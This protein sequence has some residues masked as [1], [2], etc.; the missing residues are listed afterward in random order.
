MERQAT[1]EMHPSHW[2]LVAI[3]RL[4]VI[5]TPNTSDLSGSGGTAEFISRHS[6]DGKFSFVDQ[7]VMGLLG[8]SPPELLGKS[9][10]DFFHPEDQT[11]M[12]D[13][14]EQGI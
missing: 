9:S 1:D 6:V 5:S 7:R 11:H 12:K 10:F 3:G 4:Q 14:F 8:Y 2:C 13:S